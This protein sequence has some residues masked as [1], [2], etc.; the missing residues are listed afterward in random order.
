MTM[1][2]NQPAQRIAAAETLSLSLMLMMNL[3]MVSRMPYQKLLHSNHYHPTHLFTCVTFFED[4]FFLLFYRLKLWL[5]RQGQKR[6]GEVYIAFVA[7]SFIIT[8]YRPHVCPPI[9][10]VIITSPQLSS[11]NHLLYSTYHTTRN[12]HS[13]LCLVISQHFSLK[14]KKKLSF[15]FMYISFSLW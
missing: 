14:C 6:Y 8:V 3:L 10:V 1:M 4:I 7:A 9:I 12:M 5:E 11:N 2:P 15:L 13:F